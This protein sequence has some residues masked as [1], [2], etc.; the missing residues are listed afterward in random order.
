M[1]I[2][3]RQYDGLHTEI[4]LY[5]FNSFY[6]YIFKYVSEEKSLMRYIYMGLDVIVK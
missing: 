3:N 5:F 6:Y 2:S 4:N 1:T